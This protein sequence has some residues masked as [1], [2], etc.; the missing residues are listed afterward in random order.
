MFIPTIEPA[1]PPPTPEPAQA[2]PPPASVA[3]TRYSSIDRS[4]F[5][6]LIEVAVGSTVVWTNDEGVSHTITANDLSV[7][8]PFLTAGQSFSYTFT[9]PG[10]FD[11]YCRLHQ[12][13]TATVIITG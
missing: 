6:P 4:V 1:P 2:P 3:T 7:D 13:M 8:S 11:Y 12:S 9:Q 10:T 5:E